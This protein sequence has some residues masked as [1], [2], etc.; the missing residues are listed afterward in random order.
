MDTTKAL[1]FIGHSPDIPIAPGWYYVVFET[2]GFPI[3]VYLR[4]GE[5][6]RITWGWDEEDDPELID[7]EDIKFML[8]K[9][10]PNARN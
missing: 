2:D 5:P 6:G 3:R 4:P 1:G 10:V 8:F 7:S 9:K